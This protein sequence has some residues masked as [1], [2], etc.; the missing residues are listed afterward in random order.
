MQVVDILTCLLPEQTA[1]FMNGIKVG[2]VVFILRGPRPM[3]K[4]SSEKYAMLPAGCAEIVCIFTI[5]DLTNILF[6]TIMT[7]E[8]R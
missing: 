8:A 4:Y 7:S 2:E 5:S 3:E 1:E 6:K